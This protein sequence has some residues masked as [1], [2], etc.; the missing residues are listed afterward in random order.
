[1]SVPK[2]YQVLAEKYTI[3]SKWKKNKARGP[4]PHPE[5]PREVVQMDSV[6]FG[7]I[8]AF[9]GLDCFSKEADV[10]L[11]PA[12]TSRFGHQFLDQSMARRFDSHVN[13]IQNDGGPEF[14]EEF[15]LHVMEYCDRH[16]IA[17]PYKKNETSLHRKL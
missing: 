4:V 5:N 17:R 15:T 6:D 2:I 12:L 16:R 7:G 8:F 3:R 14:K 13:L 11:A 1:L 10:L 9:T